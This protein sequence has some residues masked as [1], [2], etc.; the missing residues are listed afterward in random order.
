MNV[1]PLVVLDEIVLLVVVVFVSNTQVLLLQHVLCLFFPVSRDFASNNQLVLKMEVWTPCLLGV[2]NVFLFPINK[3][4][5]GNERK[6]CANFFVFYLHIYNLK[7]TV[8]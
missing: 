5:L 6:E 1:C 3:W 2:V 4:N 7:E 8:I